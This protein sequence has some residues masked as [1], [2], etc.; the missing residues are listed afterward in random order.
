MIAATD[1]WQGIVGNRWPYSKRPPI[2]SGSFS[3]AILNSNSIDIE[4]NVFKYLEGKGDFDECMMDFQLPN[5]T[6]IFD[7]LSYTMT[8]G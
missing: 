7:P 4:E 6:S 2:I 3:D 1:T 5:C 8:P